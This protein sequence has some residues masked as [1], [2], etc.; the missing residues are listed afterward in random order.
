[1]T[2]LFDHLAAR[3]DN[4]IECLASKI[5]QGELDKPLL[6]ETMRKLHGASSAEGAWT[7]RDAFELMEAALVRHL[8][9]LPKPRTLGDIAAFSRIVQALPTQTVR[10]ETQIRYQQFSTPA[11]LAALV[12]VL[13]Q[14]RQDDLVLE[15]SA[16]HGILAAVLP[17]VRALHLNEIDPDRREKLAILFPQATLTAIDGAMLTSLLDE[18]TRPSLI[19]MNPPF[20]RSE[21]RGVDQFA[22]IRHLRS[23][24]SKTSPGGR[25]IAIMPDW[26]TTSAKMVKIYDETFDNCTVRTSCRLEK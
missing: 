18:T 13:A 21:G 19:V 12:A 7:Q 2:D 10:S 9:S 15:P 16:G 24:I 25:I 11:D 8:A 14:A 23:A 20:S 17:Q 4:A 1:M 5:S 6:H 26:F 3:L 22:A